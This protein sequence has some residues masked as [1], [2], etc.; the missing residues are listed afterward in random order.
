MRALVLLVALTGCLPQA[1]GEHCDRRYW[2]EG[3]VVWGCTES[4][5][6]DKLET[7]TASD[8]PIMDCAMV[9]AQLGV[10]KS[11]GLAQVAVNGSPVGAC[12]DSPV[13]TCPM[14]GANQCSAQK[15][16]LQRVCQGLA[17][18]SGTWD[19]RPFC[20]GT[21]H[22]ATGTGGGISCID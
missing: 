14:V 18:D 19:T 8:A 16:Q 5:S 17:G 1:G 10:P 13:E 11:C 4:C 22:C 6:G 12:I 7:C 9:S 2:C 3:A 20:T 21:Q 15:P